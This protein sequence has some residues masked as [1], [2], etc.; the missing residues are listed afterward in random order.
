MGRFFAHLDA[1]WVSEGFLLLFF[2]MFVGLVLYWY[3]PRRRS[4]CEA[5]AKIPLD[6]R[7]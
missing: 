4:E 7:N 2:V 6:D 3:S 1:S 5:F